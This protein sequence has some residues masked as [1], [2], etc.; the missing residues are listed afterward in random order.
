MATLT[1]SGYAHGIAAAGDRAYVG[2][3]YDGGIQ[4]VDIGDPAAPVEISVTKYTMY[5]EAWEVAVDETD[6]FVVD[7]FAGVFILERGDPVRLRTRGHYFTPGSII[8]AEAIGDTIC[9]VGDLSG[10]QVI[11]LGTSDAPRIVASTDIFRGVHGLTVAA[12]AAFVTDRWGLQVYD[13]SALPRIRQTTRLPIP[14]VARRPVARGNYVYLTADLSGFHVVDVSEVNAPELIAS[15]EM[16]GFAY[17]LAIAG[18]L[19]YLA[20]S[21]TGLHILSIADP[22]A[23]HELGSLPTPGL[24]TGVAVS[25]DLVGVADGEA[26]LQLVD[27]SHPSAPLL[28]GSCPI[29]GFATDLVISGT[30]ACVADE[31]F[32]LR[33]ID[34]SDPRTPAHLASWRTPGETAQVA[35]GSECLLVSDAFSLIVLSLKGR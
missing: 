35:F 24:A 30:L 15:Y 23:P 21:D 2:G 33:L 1:T 29:D 19:A 27:A 31:S 12:G 6:V 28:I 22:A 5:N 9:A 4:L 8:A 14:G 17:G 18:E 11:D 25:G 13:L 10:L 26:G 32:G 34:I 16:T 7:Y 20:N 3:L